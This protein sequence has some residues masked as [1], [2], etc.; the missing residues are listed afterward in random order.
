M[1]YAFEV[2]PDLIDAGRTLGFLASLRVLGLKK[3][4]LV[5]TRV[6]LRPLPFFKDAATFLAFCP[7]SWKETVLC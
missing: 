3:W 5:W 4:T 7:M 6:A 2:S 1:S